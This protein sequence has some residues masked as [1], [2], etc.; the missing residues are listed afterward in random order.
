MQ[1]V[2]EWIDIQAP[3]QEVFDTV[4]DVE[5]R[6][7]LS[8]LWGLSQLLEIEPDFPKPGSS[9]RVRVLPAG[10]FGVAGAMSNTVQSALAGLAQ[11]MTWKAGQDLSELQQ[12]PPLAPATHIAAE[13]VRKE[14]A[15]VPME[16]RYFI[17]EWQ[18]PSKLS[19]Q[20]DADCKTIVTWRFQAIPFGTRVNYEEVFCDEHA[21]GAEFSSTVRRVIHEWL[22][23]IKHYAELRGARGRIFVKW[24]LDRFFLKLRPDQRRTVILIL[25]L[26]GIA[27]VTFVVAA[28][29][30]GIAAFLF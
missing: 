4:V 20:L 27:L 30:L 12:Q 17:L 25:L 21:G 15:V 14:E 13:E 29:S 9:Y 24:L 10:P 8:P 22:V 1:T 11:V 2:S 16:Q 26:Q 7:Q 18:P 6:M 23:N 19:Y 3:C 5:R 28:I